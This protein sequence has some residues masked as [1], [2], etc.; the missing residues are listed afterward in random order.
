VRA[1]IVIPMLHLPLAWYGEMLPDL[2]RMNWRWAG[3]KLVLELKHAVYGPG[4]EVWVA[5]HL[6]EDRPKA[7]T[8][9]IGCRSD[10]V[11]DKQEAIRQGL[12]RLEFIVKGN[13]I[14]V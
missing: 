11:E 5:G 4:K 7:I 6:F 8:T 12:E 14:P 10:S 3:T 1:P 13:W 9:L 2:V